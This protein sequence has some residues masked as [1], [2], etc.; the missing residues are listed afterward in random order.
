MPKVARARYTDLPL[1]NG[2]RK[3]VTHP[4]GDGPIMAP[5]R[6]APKLTLLLTVVIVAVMLFNAVI[7]IRREIDL[8]RNDTR[9]DQEVLARAASSA[10]SEAW[11]QR[12]RVAG[13]DLIN[14]LLP[15]DMSVALR[16][17]DPEGRD[18]SEVAR[19]PGAARLAANEQRVVAVHSRATAVFGDP[20]EYLTYA[21]VVVDGQIKGVVEVGEILRYHQ[22]YLRGTLVSVATTTLGI[23]AVWLLVTLVVGNW[24]VGKPMRS[25]VAKAQSVG[26]G[27]FETPLLLHRNDEFGTLAQELN[28]MSE[29]LVKAQRSL[30]EEAAARIA[31]VEQLR[32]ADRLTTV[33]KLA[34]GV[35]HELG[36]PLHVVLGRARMIEEQEVGLEEM[37]ESAAI[38]RRQTERMTRIIRQLLDFARQGT[39]QKAPRDLAQL[40]QETVDLLAPLAQKSKVT[41]TMEGTLPLRANVDASRFQQVVTNLIMNAVQAS[42]EG[43]VVTVRISPAHLHFREQAGEP[44]GDFARIQ[45]A[46]QGSG[47]SPEI[48]RHLFEPFFTTKD[49]GQGTGLGLSVAYGIVEEHDGWIAVDSCPGIGSVFTVC[50]PLL[51]PESGEP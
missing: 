42:S 26:A 44:Q 18:A 8:F 22:E 19:E 47:I 17:V 51:S 43:N 21:P 3:L 28:A 15:S 1:E 36:T 7:R 23:A 35:A 37:A 13:L 4:G 33:G 24:V 12:G 30:R 11:H 9:R 46:D 14:R 49:V 16:W 20:G 25:L 39:A 27:D 10:V 40:T 50:L 2:L 34:S 29:R 31:A 41:L 45:V 48:Q 38:I 5:M 6:L 32:H